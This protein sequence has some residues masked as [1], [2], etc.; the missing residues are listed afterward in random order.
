MAVLDSWLMRGTEL[1]LVGDEAARHS[2]KMGHAKATAGALISSSSDHVLPGALSCGQFS[3]PQGWICKNRHDLPYLD[4]VAALRGSCMQV[5]G[6]CGAL[7]VL[8][9]ALMSEQEYIYQLY[10]ECAERCCCAFC[11]VEN[12]AM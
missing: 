11:A 3:K 7:G 12:P 8:Y 5:H 10:G 9:E 6:T 4:G 1:H 2:E